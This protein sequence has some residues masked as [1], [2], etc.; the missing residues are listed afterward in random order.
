MFT[1][2]YIIE[3]THGYVYIIAPVDMRI[4]MHLEAH[5]DM[6]TSLHAYIHVYEYIITHIFDKI[7]YIHRNKKSL[8]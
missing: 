1:Y 6:C 2:G 3:H 4:C 7:F 5:T 8:S